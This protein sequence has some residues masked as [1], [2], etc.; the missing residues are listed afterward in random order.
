VCVG[1]KNEAK[2]FAPE[3]LAAMV[4]AKMQETADEGYLG[5]TVKNAVVTVQ[6]HFNDA[7][8]QAI[9]AA[10]VVGV[11]CEAEADLPTMTPAPWV[12]VVHQKLTV[13]L[14]TM[15]PAPGRSN[16]ILGFTSEMGSSS[17]CSAPR[18]RDTDLAVY[19]IRYTKITMQQRFTLF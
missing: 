1:Y 13:P 16:E 4:L 17:L 15:W 8:R 3:E 18:C 19:C 10:Y 7:Q 2:E 9:K 6:A 14:S 11:A 12:A 5:K